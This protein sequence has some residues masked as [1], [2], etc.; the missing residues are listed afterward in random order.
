LTTLAF[1]GRSKSEILRTGDSKR[2]KLP[3]LAANI[4]LALA[5]CAVWALMHRY[6][7]LSF[8]GQLYAVQALSRIFP[9][10]TND[11]YLQNVSQDRFTIFSPL[12]AT[13]IG[14]FGLPH[15]AILL[16]ALFTAL[17][18]TAA[19]FLARET[20]G[21]DMAWLT[22]ALLVT[23]VGTYGAYG[24]F[25]Y[26]EDYLTA[27]SLAEGLVVL[28]LVCHFRGM[29]S[30]GLLIAAVSLFV[31]P[32]MA[33]P[34]LLLL[35]CLW[36]PIRAALICAVAGVLAALF[37]AL[38]AATMP[39]ASGFVRVIDP[40]WL[41]IVRERSKF[42]FLQM[43]SVNDWESNARPFICLTI[44]AL[45]VEDRRVRKLCAAAALVGASGLALALIGS[46]VG[47]VAILVQGQAWRWVWVTGFTSVLL[48]VPTAFNLARNEKCGLICAMLLVAGWTFSEINPAACVSLALIFWLARDRIGDR[49]ARYLRWGS[50][51][52]AAILAAW[53]VANSWTYA[54]PTFD[55]RNEP[56]LL[57]RIKNI[58]GL[59]LPA[60]LLFWLL[61]RWIEH[62]RSALPSTL[63]C[64]ALIVPS[65]YLVHQSFAHTT[66]MGSAA[67][68]SEFRDWQKWIPATANVYVW[69]KRDSPIFAWFTLERPNYLSLDQSAGVV[70]SRA[71]ALEVQRRSQVLLPIT[72]PDWKLISR[73]N[74]ASSAKG[75]SDSSKPP[76]L[77][78]NELASMCKD[79]QLDFF[80]AHENVGFEPVRHAHDG[81]WK[82]WNLY[83]CRRVRESVST[84]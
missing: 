14:L 27:R 43:W 23:T 61:W 81:L 34:G 84:G 78:R 56:M 20:S 55:F 67:D 49:A 60:V 69:D 26:S 22:I 33:L 68:I 35:I 12:Y 79:P 50:F 47:P 64:A 52:F 38:I 3:Q 82:D 7:G 39:T 28:T 48:L 17:F 9:G 63:V 41:E 32:L 72:Y 4:A 71:T 19:W 21:R 15:A 75:K 5:V 46:L 57:Q 1:E 10:L 77:T 42:L 24:V 31:H 70:F 83:D 74:Q 25:H 6:R 8:D 51:A 2:S 11:L 76:T 45:S 58:F 80:I 40:V 65:A 44:T 37:V 73:S 62:T 53:I 18:L 59:Q 66:P 29:R 30:L 16:S 13:F 36:L 54:S